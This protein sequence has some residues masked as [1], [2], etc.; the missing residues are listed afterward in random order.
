L[1]SALQSLSASLSSG[2]AASPSL[3][4]WTPAIVLLVLVAGLRALLPTK[5]RRR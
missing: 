2:I 4:A 5:R 3:G 1:T